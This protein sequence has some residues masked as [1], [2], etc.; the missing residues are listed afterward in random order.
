MKFLIAR[1][2][3]TQGKSIIKDAPK[4]KEE[5]AKSEGQ[6][7]LFNYKLAEIAHELDKVKLD[8]ITPIDALNI[9][10]KMKEN[11]N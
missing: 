1:Y 9:L 6:M 10:S 7:D 3:R 2:K 11:M 4:T 8:E 5:K